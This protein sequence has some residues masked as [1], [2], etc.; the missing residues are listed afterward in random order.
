MAA[1]VALFAAVHTV[2]FYADLIFAVRALAADFIRAQGM[3]RACAHDTVAANVGR[4]ADL[5][6]LCVVEADLSRPTAD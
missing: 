4:F 2:I 1:S 6:V 5:D 3:H